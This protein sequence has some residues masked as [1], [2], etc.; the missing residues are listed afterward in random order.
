MISR[1]AARPHYAD[2]RAMSSFETGG[3]RSATPLYLILTLAAGGLGLSV[4]LACGCGADTPTALA[5][6]AV[7]TLGHLALQWRRRAA[8]SGLQGGP[9]RDRADMLAMG[10]IGAGVLLAARSGPGL[11]VVGIAAIALG[12]GTTRP[13][14]PV[15]PVWRALAAGLG[16]WLTVVGV[17]QAH[18]HGFSAMGALMGG[19]L[20]LLVAAAH[21]QKVPGRDK[22]GL[23]LLSGALA[24][25]GHAWLLGWRWAD[26]LPTSAW[27][28]LAAA[29]L[30]LAA[31]VAT[32]AG[33]SRLGR[34][35]GWLAAL[36]H[37]LL[38]TAALW[39]VVALR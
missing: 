19:G 12:W 23:R 24:L 11:L 2:A 22:A 33:A 15:A 29:P 14:L 18:R 6:V 26:W 16:S 35:W 34:G 36:L 5:A 28:A 10:V 4:A 38:L 9:W 31:G 7:A 25:A 13:G 21:L 20:A 30:S 3:P 1:I 27:W 8:A 39:A 17:D 32:M 37:A